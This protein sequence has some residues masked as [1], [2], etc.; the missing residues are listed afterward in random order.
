MK[1][2]KNK[3]NKKS[4]V[5]F[6]KILGLCTAGVLGFVGLSVGVFALFGG[7]KEKVVSLT[8]MNFEQTAYVLD[9]NL[10]ITNDEDAKRNG[11]FDTSIK[12]LPE[13]EDATKLDVILSGGNNIVT[14]PT[15]KNSRVAKNLNIKLATLEDESGIYNKG[16]EFTLTALQEEDLLTTSAKVFVESRINSF[17]LSTNIDKNAIYPGTKF[18]VSVSDILPINSLNKPISNEFY[19]Y[20]G[21]NYFNKTFLFFSSNESVA[22]VNVLTGEVEVLTEGNFFIY[23][24]VP[25]TF[26]NNANIPLKENY[27]T[28]AEYFAALEDVALDGQALTIKRETTSFTSKPI[29]VSGITAT[30]SLFNLSVNN[31]YKY[32]VNGE[33]A[34]SD[35]QMNLNFVLQAPQNSNFTSE[36]L[37]YRLQD[38]QIFE[39]FKN[40]NGTFSISGNQVYNENGVLQSNYFDISQNKNPLYYT[41]TP[42]DHTSTKDLYL[43]ARISNVKLDG[44]ENDTL[45]ENKPIDSDGNYEYYAFVKVNTNIIATESINLSTNKVLGSFTQGSNYLETG[46]Q[47][48]NLSSLI[49][50]VYP[51]NSTYNLQKDEN[52]KF[53]YIKF[54]VDNNVGINNKKI[55]DTTQEYTDAKEEIPFVPLEETIGEGEDAETITKSGYF[56]NALQ[57]GTIKVYVAVGKQGRTDEHFEDL[58][59]SSYVTIVITQT[60][61]FSEMTI[62]DDNET[63]DEENKVY[64][65]YKGNS[66]IISFKTD[67]R[68][69]F[70]KAYQEG[71]F[72]VNTTTSEKVL[73]NINLPSGDGID[74]IIEV[75]IT[76]INEGNTKLNL[77]F[78]GEKLSYFDIDNNNFKEFE[79]LNLNIIDDAL[80]SISIVSPEINQNNQLNLTVNSQSKEL[81]FLTE[82]NIEV[83]EN[84]PLIMNVEIVGGNH[85]TILNINYSS[86]AVEMKVERDENNNSLFKL[87]ITPF[88]LCENV[89]FYISSPMSNVTSQILTLN[90]TADYIISAN[91]KN[92]IIMNSNTYEQVIGGQSFIVEPTPESS[93]FLSFKTSSG[94]N[95]EPD[96]FAIIGDGE[97]YANNS[98]SSVK[99]PTPT[100]IVVK[101]VFADE[102][103]SKT[104]YF[105]IMPEIYITTTSLNVNTEG[106][107]DLNTLKG[108]I[109][110]N[111][112]EYNLNDGVI[113]THPITN[114]IN[115]FIYRDEQ[116]TDQITESSPYKANAYEF[117]EKVVELYCL[118]TYNDLDYTAVIN[119]VVNSSLQI[120]NSDQYLHNG[121][122]LELSELFKII[123]TDSDD[124]DDTDSDD[125]ADEIKVS[126]NQN[127]LDFLNGKGIIFYNANG[128]V[129]NPRTTSEIISMEIPEDFNEYILTDLVA[130]LKAIIDGEKV[131]KENHNFNLSFKITDLQINEN[132]V[133]VIGDEKI[134]YILSPNEV[135]FDNFK[136]F[137]S[138][139]MESTL[140][141]AN[142][143][144]NPSI[145][146]D[147]EKK[148]IVFTLNKII[149]SYTYKQI[150]FFA[151]KTT[152]DLYIGK[153][154]SIAELIDKNPNIYTNNFSI[155][156]LNSDDGYSIENNNLIIKT[157]G[158][159][160]I[161][162]AVL[163]RNFVVEGFEFKDININKLTIVHSNISYELLSTDTLNILKDN[164]IL[165]KFEILD[166]GENTV[167]NSFIA[168]ENVN[169]EVED[170]NYSIPTLKI[171]NYS[172]NAL[173]FKIKT[174][175]YS[176]NFTGVSKISESII[177]YKLIINQKY[178]ETIKDNNLVTREILL[179]KY[180]HDLS[181][182]IEILKDE[183]KDKTTT[184]QFYQEIQKEE[185]K[186]NLDELVPINY[187]E[188]T[189]FDIIVTVNDIEVKRINFYAK[190]YSIQLV[191]PQPS[192]YIGQ[193]L[194]RD[195]LLALIKVVD[196]SNN[197]TSK[198][199]EYIKFED[200]TGEITTLTLTT[201][202]ITIKAILSDTLRNDNVTIYSQ[203]IKWDPKFSTDSVIIYNDTKIYDYISANI[204]TTQ[205]VL[206]YKP[207]IKADGYDCNVTRSELNNDIYSLFNGT[208]LIGKLNAM[209]GELI[210]EQNAKDNTSIIVI[211]YISS[212]KVEYK[213]PIKFIIK[214]ITPA[215]NEGKEE[216]EIYVGDNTTSLTQ[217]GG[218]T[219]SNSTLTN[220]KLKFE[221]VSINYDQTLGNY[222]YH[223]N[224]KLERYEVLKNGSIV[225][226]LKG[227]DFTCTSL[228]D[229]LTIKV[230]GLL[231]INETNGYTIESL[232]NINLPVTLN[233]KN[234][235]IELDS[236]QKI[237]AEEQD[238]IVIDTSISDRYEVLPK[239]NG[240][241]RYFTSLEFKEAF[242]GII[243]D[244]KGSRLLNLNNYTNENK[245]TLPNGYEINIATHSS[246]GI[247][248]EYIIAW[249]KLV[250]D[251]IFITLEYTYGSYVNNLYIVLKPAHHIL[252][253]YDSVNNAYANVVSPAEYV[254][255]EQGLL[256]G[257]DSNLLKEQSVNIKP[258][259]SNGNNNFGFATDF[260]S[261]EYKY[262]LKYTK[263]E[264]K[265]YLTI[266]TNSNPNI[267]IAEYDVDEF[268]IQI[269]LEDEYNYTYN[270]KIENVDVKILD[271]DENEI[272]ASNPLI[273]ASESTINLKEFIY[274]NDNKITDT[275]NEN[276]NDIKKHID[277]I[278][279][280]KFENEYYEISQEGILS[281]IGTIVDQIEV[282]FT[283]YGA[284]YTIVLQGIDTTI[285]FEGNYN[286]ATGKTYYVYIKENSIEENST[287][288]SAIIKDSKDETITNLDGSLTLNNFLYTQ[289][290]STYNDDYF[291]VTTIDNVTTYKFGG[292]TFV[293]LIKNNNYYELFISNNISGNLNFNL[294]VQ[295][296]SK[297]DKQQVTIKNEDIIVSYIEPSLF[298]GVTYQ[299][300]LSNETLNLD[301]FVSGF[302][303]TATY[304]LSELSTKA[305]IV[306]NILTPIGDI[307]S[308]VY[309][310]IN[311]SVNNL[312]NKM[313][314]RIIPEYKFE[315][316]KTNKE[317]YV[318]SNETINLLNFARVYEFNG[319]D[320]IN[321]PVYKQLLNYIDTQ[322]T[323]DISDDILITNPTEFNITKNTIITIK[324]VELTFKI[325]NS[326]IKEDTENILRLDE[327]E[328]TTDIGV[329]LYLKEKVQ[330]LVNSSNLT[331]KNVNYVFSN[332]NSLINENGLFLA[333]TQG[334]YLVEVYINNVMFV[335]TI[336]VDNV[337]ISVE[338]KN[339]IVKEE[340][341]ALVKYQN[342]YATQT[343]ETLGNNALIKVNSNKSQ[344]LQYSLEL[345]SSNGYNISSLSISN[346]LGVVEL[347]DDEKQLL[348][349]F[350]KNEIKCYPAL[351]HEILARVNLSIENNVFVENQLNIRLLPI[352]LTV[353]DKQTILTANTY[354]STYDL[355]NNIASCKTTAENNNI[356]LNDLITFS[357]T[358]SRVEI[359]G[360]DEGKPKQKL[361]IKSSF[362][363][364]D[365]V[366]SIG[367]GNNKITKTSIITYENSGAGIN[368]S[369]Q[370]E[371]K[372]TFIYIPQ[373]YA[374]SAIRDAEGYYYTYNIETRN[375][376]NIYVVYNSNGVKVIEIDTAGNFN[377]FIQASFSIIVEASGLNQTINETLYFSETNQNW[378][379][380]YNSSEIKNR[381]IVENGITL[382]E[383]LSGE[384]INIT[385]FINGGEV[386]I[387]SLN[388]LEYREESDG[389]DISVFIKA[390][391][392]SVNTYSYFDV[393]KNEITLRVY[394]KIYAYIINYNYE[395]DYTHNGAN[396]TIL[397]P[398]ITVISTGTS[399]K[400]EYI[401]NKTTINLKDYIKVSSD[402]LMDEEISFELKWLLQFN[403]IDKEYNYFTIESEDITNYCEFNK[404]AGTLTLK[405]NGV[406]YVN[407]LA[408]LSHEEKE[409]RLRVLPIVNKT[410]H[411]DKNVLVGDVI[412]L[413]K[414]IE[415][416]APNE[417][418]SAL[419][420]A[421][422]NDLFTKLTFTI[423]NNNLSYL[424]E[425]MLYI[426][427]ENKLVLNYYLKNLKLGSFNIL[428][429][430]DTQEYYLLNG[431]NYIEKD[432][433]MS[434]ETENIS[435]INIENILNVSSITLNNVNYNPTTIIKTENVLESGK[436]VKKEVKYFVVEN[437][438]E[439][440]ENGT[441]KFYNSNY[442]P[443]S[444]DSE[445]FIAQNNIGIFYISVIKE[446]TNGYGQEFYKL[447]NYLISYDNLNKSASYIVNGQE[448][449]YLIRFSL[450]TNNNTTI[451]NSVIT[452][453]TI[454]ANGLRINIF[455]GSIAGSIN[456]DTIEMFIKIYIQENN[457]YFGEKF[458]IIKL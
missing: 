439:I 352:E 55:V 448:N 455:D 329:T 303:G 244:D 402:K 262:N 142:V 238:Y 46:S 286:L 432:Y 447:N 79:E 436:E 304:A 64:N 92:S 327:A 335:T 200:G 134:I 392:L 84:N 269:T 67:N 265:I 133:E 86:N 223:L 358:D 197:A 446:L 9:G 179:N 325:D 386:N 97:L 89:E 12:L 8:G 170:T 310:Q 202:P 3:K 253:R 166:K 450:I 39:G 30:T 211:P 389:E 150:N 45:C 274:I 316:A 23:A 169:K 333:T 280:T 164:A 112:R 80:T 13:N 40:P 182:Y 398:A 75:N 14:L 239:E 343:I 273:L 456:D 332:A 193:T 20:F 391:D 245:I 106:T 306:G 397:D 147:K 149:K 251:Y 415:V 35:K 43:I 344:N 190:N 287:I 51:E 161:T 131:T 189:N 10:K 220:A 77:L 70:L 319:F 261:S 277:N 451:E 270:I 25:T 324:D 6:L 458:K 382:I 234:I 377:R 278:V 24:Y 96:L 187:S 152:K 396:I 452:E 346:T 376:I 235:K 65:L 93:A 15:G 49:A 290:G 153:A 337:E 405:V 151:E 78:N 129:D 154:Y 300:M 422:Q 121:Q 363:T 375:G 457:R 237:N 224:N 445:K 73:I 165:T 105:Y 201:S 431:I 281:P 266:S 357:V 230:K 393:T 87:S 38:I 408:K 381:I 36:Q 168:I 50:S 418:G 427:D 99:V 407:V 172:D 188:S 198:Y 156:G 123:N 395:E 122:K 137:V 307:Y 385:D 199:N 371:L 139:S 330:N 420:L 249:D 217:C 72:V 162:F 296:S 104:F 82:N 247:N 342:I 186:I 341:N 206:N 81:Q 254:F 426:L 413:S 59:I 34:S 116:L 293:E 390:S 155:V 218:F 326:L 203:E 417:Q 320:A 388:N 315:V 400:T 454:S 312:T 362:N 110:L 58:F 2:K 181:K 350:S 321:E 276:Y 29:N 248:T 148:Q 61:T 260:T 101:P 125:L 158:T 228:M 98:F 225:A 340:N 282:E 214:E 136:Y 212:S 241:R 62:L 208:N 219:V 113:I 336:K 255:N 338:Y 213:T 226:W 259:F 367:E 94:V 351:K 185:N 26:K 430:L 275:T 69:G 145:D 52:G 419:V 435:A 308:D 305:T 441:I 194:N 209:T 17:N 233:I 348:F 157:A 118:V 256:F 449:N 114:S 32:S 126:F 33:Y 302:T 289:A 183:E 28:D 108:V 21:Q 127:T 163:G 380:N 412:D 27:N 204:G 37:A 288:I 331:F 370:I 160:N 353:V 42:V 328:V 57:E 252:F 71:F 100:Q 41:I 138:N 119:V 384:E 140:D 103:A 283:L 141:E 372:D 359:I 297:I 231:Y 167:N 383:L 85:Q 356:N 298:N 364:I 355:I 421:N 111:Q 416:T 207:C 369:Q 232:G 143:E 263:A 124:S 437:L 128:K 425:N 354:N 229:S 434:D 1:K 210:I 180:S 60:I 44:I 68:E 438:I 146:I 409:I 5:K 76:A 309:L 16:G 410:S 345:L 240:E 48:L 291:T 399:F 299:N 322:D 177:L 404:D 135:N 295:Y 132:F 176:E 159:Y 227:S 433:V 453:T 175:F 368:G 292:Q 47:M 442:N 54:Y 444:E 95:Y 53:K 301:N 347:R 366:I 323:E 378:N 443:Q 403:D 257:I 222:S 339:S 102:S 196:D 117:D 267:N 394:I 429:S 242:V 56:V 314:V 11:V 66:L 19:T 360:E 250:V 31:T 285:N 365:L 313:F 63:Y 216:L 74:G 192:F 221:I 205:L 440:C 401:L 317:F 414:I 294:N 88:K 4:F 178:F 272:N 236:E 423:S 349:T 374:I 258:S 406:Y 173:E 243:N 379:L 184:I 411:D 107:I 91:Y 90:I 387:D 171:G 120:Q 318:L 268:L 115:K 83:S 191:T 215:P 174:T 109:T 361:H 279:F 7:F 22:S 311:I 373:N 130:N 264:N 246:E 428:P 424:S 284:P 271:A 334:E 144:V 195:E 18:T